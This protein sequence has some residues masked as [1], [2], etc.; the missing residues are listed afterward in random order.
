MMEAV[1][2]RGLKET[3]TMKPE[4][5]KS[6]NR[7]SWIGDGNSKSHSRWNLSKDR[8]EGS[9]PKRASR[10]RHDQARGREIRDREIM[11]K[12]RKQEIPFLTESKQR[13]WWRLWPWEDFKRQTWSS[14]ATIYGTSSNQLISFLKCYH[15]KSTFYFPK[16]FF[17]Y[18][19]IFSL[20]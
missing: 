5:G 4:D 11:N 7:K 15:H 16:I 13:S 3:N 8:D 2:L 18:S 12:R 17:F 9:D 6:E 14:Q 1:T 20:S 19:H 10:D